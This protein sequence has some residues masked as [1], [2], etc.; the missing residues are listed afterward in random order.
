M[1]NIR[2]EKSIVKGLYL[3]SREME[4]RRDENNKKIVMGYNKEAKQINAIRATLQKQ[5]K[6]SASFLVQR[7]PC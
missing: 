1:K 6:K 4:K 5:Q 3:K 2:Y 7:L